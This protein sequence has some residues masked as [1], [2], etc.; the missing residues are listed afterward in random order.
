[1]TQTQQRA[2]QPTSV[3]SPA[4]TATFGY[5]VYVA[6]MIAG[7]VFETNMDSRLGHTHPDTAWQSVTD[8]AIEYAI[9]LVGMAIAILAGRRAWRAQ[10]HR[11]ARTALI[12]AAVAAV[13]VVAFWAGWPNIFG[14]VAVGLALEHRRRVGS[15]GAATGTSLVLGSAAFVAGAASC[16]LG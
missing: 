1:M 5:V 11:L 13:T 14:A 8:Y 2:G 9:G 12:L 10:P 3:L 6:A 4:V 15:L 7:N 16:L